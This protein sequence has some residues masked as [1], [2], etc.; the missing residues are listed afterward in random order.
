MTSNWNL[1]LQN[2]SVD[3]WQDNFIWGHDLGRKFAL[4]K[5][6]KEGPMLFYSCYDLCTEFL[7][8]RWPYFMKGQ[9]LCHLY[10]FPPTGQVKQIV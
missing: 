8:N 10:I 9:A 5:V 7:E 2:E 1:T 4:G 3:T 6:L